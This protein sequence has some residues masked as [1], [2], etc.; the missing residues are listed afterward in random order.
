MVRMSKGIFCFLLL[1]LIP[2]LNGQSVKATVSHTQVEIGQEFEL[3]FSFEMKTTGE[4]RFTAPNLGN[5]YVF[6]GPN[7]SRSTS[8]INMDLHVTGSYSY[9][10]SAKKEGSFEIPGA[11]IKIDGKTFRTNS[12]KVIVKKGAGGKNPQAGSDIQQDLQNE[13]FIR[14]IVDKRSALVGEQITVTYKLYF[15]PALQPDNPN[16]VKLP[17]FEG[18]WA[19]E[20]DMPGQVMLDME[21][22]NGRNYYAGVIKTAALF[23]TKTGSLD[24]S[25]IILTLPVQVS[26]LRNKNQTDDF[27]NDPFFNRSRKI[28]YKITSTPAKVEISSLP[29]DLT[30][31]NFSGG[32]GNFNVKTNTRKRVYK[33][34]EPI[35][36]EILISGSG[37]IE[38]VDAGRIEFDKSFEVLD[39]NINKTIVR[40]GVISGSKSIEYVLIPRDGGKYVLPSVDFVYFD[41]ASK[42]LKTIKTEEIPLTISDVSYNEGATGN[43]TENIDI[44]TGD[45]DLDDSPPTYPALWFVI[46]LFILPAFA[47]AFFVNY[48][49]KE[50]VRLSDP[51]LL[52]RNAARK[53]AA[54]K[55]ATAD[56]MRKTANHDLFYTET[57]TAL[58]GYLEAKYSLQKSEFTSGVVY[59]KLIES[60]IE[61]NLAN[62]VKCL[63]D[64]CELMRF[65]PVDGKRERMDEFYNRTSVIIQRFEG[66][67]G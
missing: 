59:D 10:L 40:T 19:E 39:P 11:I 1:L 52:K 49:K 8:L 25:P 22:Y 57:A 33:R 7:E 24:I 45:I 60:G 14:T 5:F 63:L 32:V 27:F 34:N 62:D 48:K 64:D 2:T 41:L 61:A 54:E 53:I 18:F 28:D 50:A 65:A 66:I 38:L 42:E 51:E 43:E 58:E 26:T 36:F 16:Y 4:V 37:N 29:V 6:S 35:R 55:L 56:K 20:I 13:I 21:N 17:T 15:N 12:V 9:I 44:F 3:S 67:N 46:T 30:N 47:T 23:A 31:V